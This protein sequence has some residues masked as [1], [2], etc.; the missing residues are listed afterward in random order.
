MASG[1]QARRT[2]GSH[3]WPLT[4]TPG[5][6]EGRA[7]GPHRPGATRGQGFPLP[8]PAPSN[9][10]PSHTALEQR[11]RG[12]PPGVENETLSLQMPRG[13]GRQADLSSHPG[14]AV[15]P[16]HL[17]LPELQVPCSSTTQPGWLP[18][19]VCK[20]AKNFQVSLMY[21]INL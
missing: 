14:S 15:R 11:P 8:P 6:A 4:G 21:V 1:L 12:E 3:S 9:I 10:S 5:P 13:P 19:S 7:L 17:T 20:Q 2:H 18:G 16:W